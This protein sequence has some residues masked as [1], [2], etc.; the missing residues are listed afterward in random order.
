MF[1]RGVELF[2]CTV[3]IITC[4]SGLL[5]SHEPGIGPT[6]MFGNVLTP[7]CHSPGSV[8]EW[9]ISLA[10]CLEFGNSLYSKPCWTF[11]FPY[12]VVPPGVPGKGGRLIA[13]H[14]PR[15]PGCWDVSVS[16]RA[17]KGHLPNVP[18]A[19]LG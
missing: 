10:L 12:A 6:S 8:E 9:L 3:G 1:H 5:Q 14:L 15:P 11:R 19:F 16:P 4:I 18:T 13:A 7:V 2:S 17:E